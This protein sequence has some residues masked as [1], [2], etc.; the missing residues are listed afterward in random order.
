M[1]PKWA[2]AKMGK[3][4]AKAKA[5]AMKAV[6]KTALKPRSLPK[7]TGSIVPSS[8]LVGKGSILKPYDID[9]NVQ[10]ASVNM[11]KFYRMQVVESK[12]KSK[13]W[14]V[15]HWGRIGTA[16]QTQVKGPSGKEQAVKLM[17]SK[18]RSK[19]GK[20]WADRG[21][22]GPGT[23]DSSARKGHGTYEMTAR[24][25]QAGARMATKPGQIAISLMWD[26]SN[27]Q[28]RNDLDL[29]VTAPSGEKIG[30][31]HKKS[32]C[33]GELDVDRRQD[34]PKPVENIVW[35]K[36]APKG[37]YTVKVHN[38]SLNHKRSIPFQVGIVLDGG[39]RQ[40]LQKT[41]T[42]KEKAWVLVKKFKY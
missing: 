16:G 26:H 8:G 11:S 9:L 23:G 15:Q 20:S 25:K 17:E 27:K 19:T 1:A 41:M 3:A 29:W 42:A 10:D 6:M 34:A 24:L 4:K 35:S 18:F 40:M 32:K 2:L 37:N 28:I 5:T 36:K 31:S 38:F 21:T 33:G 12:D 22:A 7:S 39:E 14:F 13:Y 30:F